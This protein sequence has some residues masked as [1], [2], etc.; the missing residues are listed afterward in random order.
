MSVEAYPTAN[1]FNN[2]IGEANIKNLLN[3]QGRAGHGEM[4]E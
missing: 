1:T 2:A 3:H 4:P